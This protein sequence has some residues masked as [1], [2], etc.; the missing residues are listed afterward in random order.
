MTTPSDGPVQRTVLRIAIGWIALIALDGYVTFLHQ[1]LGSPPGGWASQWWHPTQF[2]L[3]SPTVG[4][5]AEEPVLATLRL[6]LPALALGAVVFWGTASAIARTL[7]VTLVFGSLLVCIVAFYAEG[8]WELFHWRMSLVIFLI[9]LSIGVAIMSPALT[10]AWLRRGVALRLLLYVPVAFAVVALMRNATG[11]DETLT[12]NF[13]PWPGITIFGLEMGAYTVVGVLFGLGIGLAAL[14]Q[15]GQRTGLALVGIAIGC[16]FPAIWFQQR[17]G[18]EAA[19]LVVLTIATAIALALAGITRH[20]ERAAR[21][22]RRATVFTLGAALVI[23]PVL[24]GRAWAAA[25]YTVNKFVRAR[26]ATDALASY[27]AKEGQYPDELSALIEAGYLKELPRPRVGFE[28]LYQTGFLPPNEFS[29]RNLG[30]SYVLEFNSTE[31]VQC[32][33]NPPWSAGGAGGEYEEEYEDEEYADEYDSKAEEAWSC[34]DTRPALWGDDDE[35]GEE[36]EEYS[37]YDEDEYAEEE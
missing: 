10:D 30:S 37:E 24:A 5:W 23:T 2:L 7:A 13:S 31:W 11:T 21:L 3:L 19:T 4:G 36:Y 29:Y 8:A 27:Y 15:W 20:G 28:F 14:A 26:I 32:A 33:Y 6:A 25:D 35:G 22:G 16:V 1:G 18:G 34:P 12:A 17:F 9:A